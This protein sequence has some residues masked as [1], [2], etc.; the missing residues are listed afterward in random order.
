MKK[1]AHYILLLAIIFTISCN[2]HEQQ[3]K[4][5][6]IKAGGF[7]VYYEREGKGDAIL[8]VHAGLQDHT[9]WAEQVK[10]LSQQFEVITAD[11]PY[12]G[13]TTGSDTTLLIADLIKTLLDSLHIQKT[14]I[15]GLSMGAYS[16]MDF[17]LA[18]PERV[19]KAILI[20]GGVTGYENPADTI[21][22]YWYPLFKK[23]LENKDTA[24]AAKEFTKAWAEGIYRKGDSLKAPVSQYIYKASLNTMRQ[25]QVAGWPRFQDDPPAIKRISGI[26]LPVLIIDGDKDL[27]IITDNAGYMEKNI[28]GAKRIVMK[29]VAHML[30]IERPEEL[31]KLVMDFLKQ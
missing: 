16:C 27:P 31:N 8:L 24:L 13:M 23:A 9:M 21:S 2:Q 6:S 10:A 22:M 5:G 11:L 29:D 30:N 4:S 17:L 20:A 15:A 7:Q 14:S 28:P 18:Y 19:N 3:P 25:H 26:K 12:H 1:Y